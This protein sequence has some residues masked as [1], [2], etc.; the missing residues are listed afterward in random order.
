MTII[1][2]EEPDKH[3]QQMVE[4]TILNALNMEGLN[5]EGEISISLVDAET[6]RALNRDYRQ[7]D[8]VTDVLSFPQYE[9][10]KEIRAESYL[11]LG[12]IVIN[13]ERVS[14]QAKE[15]N[16]SFER[17]L[18]YLSVHSLYHLLGFDHEDE[19]SKQEMRR[20][21]EQALAYR[22]EL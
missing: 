14:E 19:T 20:R 16:H 4:K 11:F 15:Y 12:D 7:V 21:E 5:Q 22:E 2:N 3:V 1:W 8:A 6:I 9:S 18:C 13:L 10:L 17:E